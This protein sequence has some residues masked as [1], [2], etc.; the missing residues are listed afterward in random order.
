M[1]GIK[2]R[3]EILS[4]VVLKLFDLLLEKEFDYDI[5]QQL[6]LNYFQNYEID[7]MSKDMDILEGAPDWALFSLY[8]HESSEIYLEQSKTAFENYLCNV[9][10]EI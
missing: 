10:S 2:E 6:I 5:T 9:N 1:M 4:Q 3:D 7:E 8:D